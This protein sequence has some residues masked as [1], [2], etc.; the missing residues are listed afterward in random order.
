MDLTEIAS[1]RMYAKFTGQTLMAV[2]LS[3]ACNVLIAQLIR[4]SE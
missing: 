4:Q 1:L 2:A 3:I